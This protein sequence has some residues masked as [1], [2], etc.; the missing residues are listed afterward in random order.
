MSESAAKTLPELSQLIRRG[1]AWLATNSQSHCEATKKSYDH[2]AWVNALQHYEV[3]VDELRK[4]GSDEVLA[5]K[6]DDDA[7]IELGLKNYEAEFIVSYPELA[8]I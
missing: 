7:S 1:R 3:L 6:Y 8:N 2:Q 4:L 5:W